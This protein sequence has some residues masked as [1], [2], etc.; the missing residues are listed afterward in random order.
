MKARLL[1]ADLDELEQLGIEPDEA[2]QRARAALGNRPIHDKPRE[3]PGTEAAVEELVHLLAE[4]AADMRLLQ[5][6]YT[7]KARDYQRSRAR[8]DDVEG[9][10]ADLRRDVVPQL[11]ARLRELRAR[12]G[13]L[14]RELR[15]RG[16]DPDRIGPI[17]PPETAVDPR[18][19]PGEGEPERRTIPPLPPRR[20]PLERLVDTL[21]GRS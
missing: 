15:E 4:T 21:R 1:A 7:T 19:R 6:S 12:E 14:E 2:L 9:A 10:M 20:S 11:R 16:I 5:F 17:V 18:P 3:T 13:A 8:Y